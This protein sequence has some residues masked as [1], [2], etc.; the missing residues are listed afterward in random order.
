MSRGSPYSFFQNEREPPAELGPTL[1]A[2]PLPLEARFEPRVGRRRG[3]GIAVSTALHLCL[4]AGLLSNPIGRSFGAS[5]PELGTGIAVSLVAGF[6][7]GGAQ[8]RSDSAEPPEPEAGNADVARETET[9][10]G[11]LAE[12]SETPKEPEVQEARPFIP[13]LAM[14]RVDTTGEA[15]N[16]FQGM[17]GASG[18][19]GGDPTATSDLLA[20]IARCM[21]PGFRPNLAFSHLQ[22][23]VSP[24]GR[25]T[26]APAVTSALPQLAAE[27]RRTADRIVQ[28]TL[29]CGP[30]A[31]PDVVGRVVTLA[32]D[33]SK[34]R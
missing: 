6:S 20:Q 12:S 34:V 15:A 17:T 28:A 21:P 13:R 3:L 31:H 7:A 23:S 24:D 29:L 27:D 1:G 22:L 18:A 30:Y 19:L 16:D 10:E 33:F 8:T 4:A 9:R 26:A 5:G 14:M 32:A 25:L 11:A 2:A